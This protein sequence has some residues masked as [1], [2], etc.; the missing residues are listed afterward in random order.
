MTVNKSIRPQI[1]FCLIL[2][3]VLKFK[4]ALKVSILQ[5]EEQAGW[6]FFLLTSPYLSSDSFFTIHPILI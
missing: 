1:D 2:L 3:A 5:A 4:W 6:C